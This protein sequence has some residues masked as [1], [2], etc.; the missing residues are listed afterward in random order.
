MFLPVQAKVK[1]VLENQVCP[2]LGSYQDMVCRPALYLQHPLVSVDDHFIAQL[3]DFTLL[4]MVKF[5][6]RKFRE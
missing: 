4:V 6:K 3:T 1:D 5:F 2:D